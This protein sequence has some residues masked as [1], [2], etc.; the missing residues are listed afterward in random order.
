[1]RAEVWQIN[2]SQ[3]ALRFNVVSRP[4]ETARASTIRA[5]SEGLSDARKLQLDWWIAVR[6][7][8]VEAGAFP[9]V[10]TP[11][12]Q[13]WYNLALGRSGLNLSLT[14]NTYDNKIGVR[15]YLR[16]RYGGALAYE[17]LVESR[18]EIEKEIGQKLDWNPSP[19]A[20][21]KVIAIYRAADLGNRAK[22]GEYTRWTAEM[23][24]KFREA[25]APTNSANYIPPP[26]AGPAV[27]PVSRVA[28][29]SLSSVVHTSRSVRSAGR[30]LLGAARFSPRPRARF[31]RTSPF[32]HARAG[33][34]STHLP[35]EATQ[36]AAL[37]APSLRAG[38]CRRCA[39]GD[40][41][42]GR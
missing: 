20:R 42:C 34:R 35:R 17:Q 30:A 9:S 8:L 14:A 12:A 3:P 2:D 28:S 22:W 4:A 38:R 41:G 15:V 6:D 5:A 40:A 33:V 31:T 19:D 26:Q 37:V 36:Q 1:M 24:G 29:A 39:P 11:R 25:F 18:A 10:Q 23:A 27:T 32:T 16:H 7:A 21:D 13:Y